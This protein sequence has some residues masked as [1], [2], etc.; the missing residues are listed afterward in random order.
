[1]LRAAL[2]IVSEGAPEAGE[3]AKEAAPPEIQRLAG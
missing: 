1:M 2:E 3:S